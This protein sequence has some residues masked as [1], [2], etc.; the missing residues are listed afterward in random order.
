LAFACLRWLK[1]WIR[2]T[3]LETFIY[4]AYSDTKIIIIIIIIIIKEVKITLSNELT[5]MNCYSNK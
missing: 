2:R 5:F 3:W 4:N 1:H